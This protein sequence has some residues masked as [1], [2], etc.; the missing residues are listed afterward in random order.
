MLTRVKDPLPIEKGSIVVYQIPC[1]C[2]QVYIGKTNRKL[3]TRI[4]EHKDT[5]S[6]GQTER[7]AVAEHAWE[8]SHPTRWEEASELD[9]ARRHQELLVKEALH[10]QT[11]ISTVMLA[12]GYMTA[13]YQ[14]L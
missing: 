7:S 11:T 2:G 8:H 12:L 3:E 10:I 4:K 1:S 5:C 14:P 6:K 13:G 9:G